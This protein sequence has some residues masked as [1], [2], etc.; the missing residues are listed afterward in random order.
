MKPSEILLN[1]KISN[2]NKF[3]TYLKSRRTALGLTAR[4]I[5]EKLNLSSVYICDIE[6]G[7]RHAP[8]GHLDQ[9]AE[10]LQVEE[11]E[12]DFFFD[13]AGCSHS[14]WPDINEY[15]EKNP[16]ARKAIRLARDKNML[17]EEFLKIVED[18][19][20]TL[21]QKPSTTQPKEKTK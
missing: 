19:A 2:R 6:K 8:L 14:N 9:V 10:I 13:I 4:E 11:S 5:A 17:G 7:N 16:N 18:Y 12:R 3:G 15:L 20:Q 1:P 21:E